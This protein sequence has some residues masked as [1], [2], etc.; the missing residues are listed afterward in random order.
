MLQSIAMVGL[1]LVQ[2]YLY[3]IFIYLVP[4]GL[5]LLI[6][7][8]NRNFEVFTKAKILFYLVELLIAGSSVSFILL[9]DPYRYYVLLVTVVLAIVA[10]AI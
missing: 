10:I 5:M 7:L 4:L 1:P 2:N 6:V 3:Y 9:P 8:I